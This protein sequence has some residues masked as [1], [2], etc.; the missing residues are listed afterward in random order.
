MEY[1]VLA[2][3]WRPQ[4]FEDVVGQDHVV[5]TLRNAVRLNRISHAYIF[6]GPR[7]TG[8]TS[9]ARI[10]AKSI[11][12][13]EGPAETPCNRCGNCLEITAGS[14]LDVR[15]IDGASNNGVEEI[16][17]LRE[18]IKFSPVSSRYKIYIIDEVHMLSKAAFNALLKTLEEPPPH[19]VFIFATTEIP[20]V[21][22]TILSRCQRFDFKRI[23]VRQIAENLGHIAREEKIAV[24]DVALSWIAR[25]GQGS[26]R[27]AQS[28]FDQV[29]SYAGKEIKDTDVE[30]LLDLGDRRLISELAGAVIA[31][32]AGACLKII[33]DAYYSGADVDHFYRLLLEYFMNLLTAKV[34]DGK[35]LL[36]DLPDHEVAALRKLAEEASQET[37]QRLLDILMAEEYDIRKSPEPRI[38]LEYAVVKMAYLEPLIPIDEILA[39]MEGLEERLGGGLRGTV[40]PAQRPAEGRPVSEPSPGRTYRQG[41]AGD[42]WQAL[43]GFIKEK[44]PPLSSKIDNG[45]FMSH[46]NGRLRV[47]FPKGYLFLDVIRSEAQQNL[48]QRMAEEFFGEGTTIEIATL[49]DEPQTSG[50][51][52]SNG[53]RRT[54]EI[55]NEALR[56]P[57]VQKVMDVF[58]GAEIVDVK[59][60]GSRRQ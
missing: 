41:D 33:D 48:L 5:K 20:K 30:E 60:N 50:A 13:A 35:G 44:N 15:E 26:L 24:S 19:V 47:G 42:P 25:E 52:A 3:K 1:L 11:N 12:C 16:R 46:E 36:A 14:S 4:V 55:K 51:S 56:D 27:D 58:P 9:V 28:I 31:R 8:K 34:T 29:I 38:N 18:H 54:N 21:P 32:D 49:E 45:T 40:S 23:S 10:L 57:L 17:E 37:I 59:V 43:K 7:G 39:R 6:S 2:R 22:A 53:A